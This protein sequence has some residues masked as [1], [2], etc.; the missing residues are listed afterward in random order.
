M[1]RAGIPRETEGAPAPSR[2]VQPAAGRGTETLLV[3]ED[4]LQVRELTRDILL[5]QGYQ[6]LT[7]GDGVEALRVAEA[8]EGPIHLLVTDVVLPRMSGKEL[9]DRLRTARPEVRVLYTSG[10]TDDAIVHHGVLAAGV[11]F[12]SKPF[13]I[14]SLARKVRE[15]LDAG[16]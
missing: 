13:E 3:V 7:A 1:P 9:A 10:Y 4:E 2:L 12:L 5:G 16:A 6:V 8:H 15:L 11:H 14:E